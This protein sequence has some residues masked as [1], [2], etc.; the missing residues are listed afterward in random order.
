MEP[1]NVRSSLGITIMN[2]IEVILNI[3]LDRKAVYPSPGLRKILSEG[4]KRQSIFDVHV[5]WKKLH[6]QKKLVET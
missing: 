1:R 5:T 4:E 3:S 6:K 2:N